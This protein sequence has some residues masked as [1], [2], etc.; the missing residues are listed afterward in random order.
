MNDLLNVISASDKRRNLL[1]L[2]N[3]GPRE[4][5]EIRQVLRVTSTGM[6]PQIKILEGEHLIQREGHR[7]SLTPQGKVLTCRIEPLVK[8]V[9]VL[10]RNR[11]FWR[12]HDLGV[13]PHEILMDIGMLGNYQIVGIPD[14]DFF[15]V[16]PFLEKIAGAKTIRGIAHTV[17]PEYPAFFSNLIKKGVEISLILTPGV[18]RII[19]ENY[20]EILRE[21]LGYSTAHL[22]VADRD[23]RFSCVVT[24]QNFS[25]SLFYSNGAFD[26]GHDVVSF[27]Q[28]ARD[29]GESIFAYY[30]RQSQ[31]IV[32]LD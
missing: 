1:V 18:F 2:L 30:R 22:Y 6:L 32:S 26:A 3:S 23:I 27:D 7:Y 15:N 5:D 29:W 24:D 8:A 21:W 20:R 19:Q 17:H 13:L 10:D 12:E 14:E 28:S 9:D 16:S 4:W 31:E 11:K 25:L